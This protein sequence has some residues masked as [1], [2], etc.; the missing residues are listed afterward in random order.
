MFFSRIQLNPALRKTKAALASPHLIHGMIT[1]TVPPD[2]QATDE[3]R[4]LWRVDRGHHETVLYAVTPVQ[5]RFDHVVEQLGW[6][7]APAQTTD[8]GRLLDSLQ[9]G[10]QYAFRAA[11]NPVKKKDGKRLPHVTVTQ[12]M[13]WFLDRA[14]G[15]GFSI[16]SNADYEPGHAES[17]D[18]SR[19]ESQLDG[20]CVVRR[21]DSRF[22]KPDA[23]GGRHRVAHRIAVFDGVLE[24]TN[25]DLLRRSLAF[26]IGSGKAHGCGLMTLARLEAP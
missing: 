6:Q 4:L 25:P 17:T 3:A 8:Y 24:V 9:R 1:K 23:A 21:E 5:P 2:Q 7:S 18:T 22:S 16:P 20:L 12:Q 14:D 26:G 10:Q 19:D 13:R 11:L 15:W